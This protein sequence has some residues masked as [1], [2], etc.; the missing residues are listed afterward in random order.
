MHLLITFLEVFSASLLANFGIISFVLFVGDGINDVPSLA[1]ADV[2]IA[3]GGIGSDSA[4]E[5]ADIVLA[6]DNPAQLPKAIQIARRTVSIARANVIFALFVKFS[7]MLLSV[8]NLIDGMMWLAVFADVGVSIIAI[9][10]AM[11]CLKVKK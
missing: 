11:R 2:G 6:D 1:R 4:I 5:A 7:V 8:T 10:N 3:M 9:L